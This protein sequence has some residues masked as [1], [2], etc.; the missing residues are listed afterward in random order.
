MAIRVNIDADDDVALTKAL[1][2]VIVDLETEV[3]ESHY[4]RDPHQRFDMDYRRSKP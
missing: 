4:S 1:A 3:K 2:Q